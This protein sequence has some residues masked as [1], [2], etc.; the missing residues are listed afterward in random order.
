MFEFFLLLEKLKT[1]NEEKY[2][3]IHDFSTIIANPIFEVV[4]GE[5]E[6]WEKNGNKALL[7]QGNNSI[8]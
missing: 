3:D 8:I 5:I 6:D 7:R 4:D 2:L 1:R